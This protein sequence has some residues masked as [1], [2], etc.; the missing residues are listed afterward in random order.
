MPAN[1]FSRLST[2]AK[3][4]LQ[5][6]AK[7]RSD[8]TVTKTYRLLLLGLVLVAIAL[9]LLGAY[10]VLH[11]T[12]PDT[13]VSGWVRAGLLIARVAGLALVFLLAPLVAI[14]VCNLLFPVFSEVPFFAGFRSMAP[15]RAERVRSMPGFGN[16]LAISNSLRRLSTLAVVS[17][18]CFVLSLVPIVGP[19]LAPALQLFVAAR[20]IG[21]ELLDPYFDRLRIPWSDQR[22]IVR[23]YSA[24]I[25]GL[26]LV[27][28]P[29]LAIPL[30]GP[31][32]FGILQAG[33]ARFVID[34]LPASDSRLD[35]LG[36]GS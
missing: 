20:T 7:V 23:R 5:G 36:E 19:V 16:L 3:A 34:I 21:L 2:G 1:Y 25:L 10:A 30:V 27:S 22:A 15:E 17:V 32:L 13:L 28:A 26:G 24:E 14:S 9:N 33:A 35:L 4:Q 18:G 6:M 8:P 11:L 29:L 12:T 31:L